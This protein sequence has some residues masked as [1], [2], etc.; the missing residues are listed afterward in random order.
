MVVEPDGGRSAA[1]FADKLSFNVEWSIADGR[2]TMR[3][4]GGELENKVNL[5]IGLHGREASYKILNLDE[6]QLLLLDKDGKTRYDWRARFRPSKP[7]STIQRRKVFRPVA[8]GC[9]QGCSKST[10]PGFSDW[11]FWQSQ[12]PPG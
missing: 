6:D 1:L 3:M 12:L 8:G 5:A 4:L 2:V 11:S 9:E 7:R 10:D